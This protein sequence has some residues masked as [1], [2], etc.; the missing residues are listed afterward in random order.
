MIFF[1]VSSTTPTILP[2]DDTVGVKRI[3]LTGDFSVSDAK[4]AGILLDLAEGE[5]NFMAGNPTDVTDFTF[6]DSPY[7][8]PAPSCF[9][10]RKIGL[11]PEF[12]SGRVFIETSPFVNPNYFEKK[13]IAS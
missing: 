6:P 1:D 4:W 9:L 5:S 13:E 3:I 2:I 7:G 10:V 12:G 8:Y 11:D